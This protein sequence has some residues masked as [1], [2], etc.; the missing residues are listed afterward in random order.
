M[1]KCRMKWTVALLLLGWTSTIGY[2]IYQST[3]VDTNGSI[4]GPGTYTGVISRQV[5]DFRIDWLVSIFCF[6]YLRYG[7][8]ANILFRFSKDKSFFFF[9]LSFHPLFVIVA[10]LYGFSTSK[11]SRF[12]RQ[13]FFSLFFSICC[14]CYLCYGLR[15]RRYWWV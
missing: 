1:V 10:F 4:P 15:P 3:L 13:I 12:R 8:S 14:F 7:F 2:M 11:L 9:W 6:C 5:N